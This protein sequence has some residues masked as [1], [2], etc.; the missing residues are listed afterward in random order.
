V[1]KPA[2]YPTIT[3][4]YQEPIRFYHITDMVKSYGLLIIRT[5]EHE[6]FENLLHRGILVSLKNKTAKN[7]R[8]YEVEKKS[9]FDGSRL[10]LINILFIDHDSQLSSPHTTQF[11]KYPRVFSVQSKLVMFIN[12]YNCYPDR[13]R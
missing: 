4:F 3:S 11:I 9:L 5:R 12:A 10:T 1:N 8:N 2:Y 6:K 13:T 7:H